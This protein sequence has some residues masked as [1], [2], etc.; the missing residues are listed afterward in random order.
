MGDVGK[1]FYVEREESEDSLLLAASAVQQASSVVERVDI[2]FIIGNFF[3][4]PFIAVNKFEHTSFAVTGSERKPTERNIVRRSRL[5][6][7]RRAVPGVRSD[8]S[9]DSGLLQQT[10]QSNGSYDDTEESKVQP[11]PFLV[12]HADSERMTYGVQRV[13][14]AQR[15]S[16]ES[17]CKMSR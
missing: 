11:S 12:R 2:I 16:F 3:I 7:N 1:K 5:G 13:R 4:S 6:D 15:L 14:G 9:G 10:S 8:R 17:K